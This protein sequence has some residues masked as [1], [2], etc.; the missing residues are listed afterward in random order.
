MEQQQIQPCLTVRRIPW[1]PPLSL[2]SAGGRCCSPCSSKGLSPWEGLNLAF[3][4][5]CR[6]RGPPI[7]PNPL[8]LLSFAW[9][10][11][12]FMMVVLGSLGDPVDKHVPAGLHSSHME[13]TPWDPLCLQTWD[14]FCLVFCPPDPLQVERPLYLHRN[15]LIPSTD[16]QVFPFP[17]VLPPK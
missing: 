11:R 12:S 2:S 17:P 4:Q 8:Y 1:S 15:S 10:P 3:A 14:T 9:P 5:P 7:A 13:F 16:T 6:P